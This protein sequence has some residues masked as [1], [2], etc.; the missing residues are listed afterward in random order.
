MSIRT[1]IGI[2]LLCAV[3][4]F[5]LAQFC[6]QQFVVIPGFLSL[7]QDE[8]FKDLHRVEAAVKN[9]IDRIH[10]VCGDWAGW[11]DTYDFVRSRSDHYIESNL[12]VFHIYE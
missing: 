11:D 3:A 6:I 8:A 2:I 12:G 5:G 7:E 1:K 10:S 4:G 9:E